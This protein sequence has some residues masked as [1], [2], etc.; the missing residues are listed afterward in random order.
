MS[1]FYEMHQ[2][3]NLRITDK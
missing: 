1:V 2:L 3:E